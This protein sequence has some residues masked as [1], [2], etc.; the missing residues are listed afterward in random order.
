MLHLQN[1]KPVRLPCRQPAAMPLLT[2]DGRGCRPG[3]ASRG[4]LAKHRAGA[5]SARNGCW[6]VGRQR[7]HALAVGGGV[8]PRAGGGGQRGGCHTGGA[9]SRGS[10]PAEVWASLPGAWGAPLEQCRCR[11]QG[12]AGR[13]A[14]CHLAWQQGWNWQRR[15]LHGLRSRPKAQSILGLATQCQQIVRAVRIRAFCANGRHG[16]LLA[17]LLDLQLLLR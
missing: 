4:R 17:Q 9:H 1:R 5:G 15:R 10:S 8:R 13:P 7:R 16:C 6:A 2:R 14:A 11:T 3:A 12:L